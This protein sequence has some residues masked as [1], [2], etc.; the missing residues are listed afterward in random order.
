MQALVQMDRGALGAIYEFP[1]R[2][3]WLE[4]E[5][6]SIM[7]YDRL[8]RERPADRQVVLL[9]IEDFAPVFEKAYADEMDWHAAKGLSESELKS[10]ADASGRSDASEA[11][12][13][14]A[15]TIYDAQQLRN[16]DDSFR[17]RFATEHAIPEQAWKA[18]QSR[19]LIVHDRLPANM[20]REQFEKL[21]KGAGLTFSFPAN[22]AASPRQHFA[23]LNVQL[24]D[25][26]R[27]EKLGEVR[28]DPLTADVYQAPECREAR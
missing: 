20:I 16:L 6:D 23:E 1:K 21:S 5:Q 26:R 11:A 18:M 4:A 10:T 14:L 24:P 12:L 27:F 13:S 3:V 15:K 28:I 17:E 2:G 19:V 9:K 8:L 7:L 25:G 22:P